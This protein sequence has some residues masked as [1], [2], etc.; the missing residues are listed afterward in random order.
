MKL[1]KR[2]LA[3]LLLCALLLPV[4]ASCASANRPLAYLKR[5]IEK[6]LDHRLGGPL[7]DLLADALHEGSIAV[8]FGG[9]DAV[10]APVDALD[11]KVYFTPDSEALFLTGNLTLEGKSYDGD[12]WLDTE[13]AVL[14]SNALL[15]SVNFG[16]DFETLEQDL[17]NSVFRNNSG[18]AYA[19]PSIDEG[20]ADA[21]RDWKNGLFEL[22]AS[23]D[24]YAAEGDF[25]LE[26]FLEIL[27]DYAPNTR[28]S[29]GGRYH[30]S[31]TVE[32]NQL[33]R[34]L[35]DTHAKLT[36]DRSF[37]RELRALAATRDRMESA[38]SGTLC[39]AHTEKVNYWLDGTGEIESL[40]TKI[41]NDPAFTL[42]IN[43]SV[44]RLNGVLETA[45][46]FYR[47]EGSETFA[48]TLDLTDPDAAHGT[49]LYK[50]VRYAAD[51]TVTTD[52]WRS[53]AADLR[54]ARANA[55]GSNATEWKGTLAVNKRDKTFSLATTCG[56][57][58]RT[59]T[60]SYQK[61][62]SSFTLTVDGLT[63]N[64]AAKRFALSLTV[65]AE[66]TAPELPDYTNL[67]AAP[68]D[69]VA[70]VAPR[71]TAAR[72]QFRAA[73]DRAN[74]TKYTPLYFVEDLMGI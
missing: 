30:F 23:L 46:I 16:V 3:L 74:I 48:L 55:D 4:L 35:R 29:E 25:A 11:A 65:K 6:T 28:Y 27:T 26:T 21:I 60:G 62:L 56:D 15:G 5:S 70:A 49:L 18:T 13:R 31:I 44:R 38:K 67:F 69:R 61:K 8:S 1:F 33:A 47:T 39:T 66:D 10:S 63:E 45:N 58:N 59:F 52:K 72:D 43:A 42:Q 73:W 54:F 34:A 36:A 40:C 64:G 14:R 7:S 20:T 57:L 68:E 9:T 12:L 37:C 32:N 17:E 19:S 53:Y 24:D 50:G 71:F 2:A 22:Y 41:D 51:Y